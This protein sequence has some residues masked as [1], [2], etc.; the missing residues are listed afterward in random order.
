[1]SVS[2]LYFENIDIKMDDYALKQISKFKY[3]LGSTRTGDGKNKAK[4]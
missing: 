4:N 3:L 1:V 2:Y